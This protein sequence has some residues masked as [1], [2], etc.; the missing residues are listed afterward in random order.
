MSED[1][2]EILAEFKDELLDVMKED[3]IPEEDF[4]AIHSLAGY[5]EKL[6]HAKNG[7]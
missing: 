5:I 1:L 3:G 4:M 7:N 6:I 2:K